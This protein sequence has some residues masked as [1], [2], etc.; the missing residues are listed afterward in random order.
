MTSG[1]HPPGGSELIGDTNLIVWVQ[2][3][4]CEMSVLELIFS[5]AAGFLLY[6]L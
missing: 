4:I 6:L 3:S 5:F 2:S 1:S